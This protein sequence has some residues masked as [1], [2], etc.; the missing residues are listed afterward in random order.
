MEAVMLL[1]CLSSYGK[2]FV[3]YYRD[4]RR[5][6]LLGGCYFALTRQRRLVTLRLHRNP[7]GNLGKEGYADV[8]D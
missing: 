1:K 2:I 7:Q 3:E 4:G 5:L 6:A 8:D